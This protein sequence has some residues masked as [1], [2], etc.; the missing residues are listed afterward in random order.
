MSA[1]ASRV[2]AP[3]YAA[4]ALVL[5]A[6]CIQ[7][8]VATQPVL[9]PADLVAQWVSPA[10][11]SIAFASNYRF[12]ATDLRLGKFWGFCAAAGNI[13]GSGT[14]QFLSPEGDSGMYSKGN[15]VALYFNNTAGNPSTGCIAGAL[16]LTSWNTGSTTGLCVQFDPDTPCDGYVFQKTR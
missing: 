1:S 15:L 16:E 8:G 5:L 3:V 4:A 14:W 13:S 10:G 12:T 7:I 6:A 11:G 2:I 9:S